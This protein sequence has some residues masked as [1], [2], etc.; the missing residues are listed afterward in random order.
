LPAVRSR[1][2]PEQN[3]LRHPCRPPAAANPSGIIAKGGIP[4]NAGRFTAIALPMVP[5][6]LVRVQMPLVPLIRVEPSLRTSMRPPVPRMPMVAV[7]VEIAYRFL[8]TRPIRPVTV[9]R[10]PLANANRPRSLPSALPSKL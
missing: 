5:A 6:G 4:L 10:A 7:G 9:R 2:M 1:K 8:L 3:G